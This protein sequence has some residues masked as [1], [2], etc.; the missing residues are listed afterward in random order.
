MDG[1][2][3]VAN[4]V[5]IVFLF[6]SFSSPAQNLIGVSG[7]TIGNSSFVVE[8][9]VGEVAIT[10]LV[11]IKN[12]VTQGLLQPNLKISN[13]S[14]EIINHELLS[15][16]NPTRDKI[17]LVGRYDW[18]TDYQIF[19]TDGKLIRQAKFSNNYIDVSYLPSALY[20][21]KLFPGCNENYRVLKVVKQ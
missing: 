20:F 2:K 9:A 21:I 10:T 3:R 17:R 11:D 18:I 15:F 7:N 4:Y 8:Y 13:P 19:S 6:L 5:S 12:N 16:E 14:C 1:K